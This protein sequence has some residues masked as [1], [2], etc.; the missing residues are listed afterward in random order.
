MIRGPQM[1]KKSFRKVIGTD[2]ASLADMLAKHGRGKD[3]MLAHITPGEAKLLKKLGG[4][5]TTNPKTGLPEFDDSGVADFSYQAP[6]IDTYQAPTTYSDTP[7]TDRIAAGGESFNPSS[8]TPPTQADYSQGFTTAAPAVGSDVNSWLQNDPGLAT[9]GGMTP[10]QYAQQNPGLYPKGLLP[11]VGQGTIF[12]PGSGSPQVQDP[13][14][15]QGVLATQSSAPPEKKGFLDELTSGSTLA[16]LGL[17]AGAGGLGIIQGNK[18]AK[19]SQALVNQQQALGAP[20][21][22]KGQAMIDAATSGQLSPASAQQFAAA[23]AQAQ[24][25]AQQRGG[26]G[27]QQTM[28]TLENMRQRLLA[29]DMNIGVQLAAEGDNIASGAITAQMNADAAAAQLQQNY[30]KSVFGILGQIPVGA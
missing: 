5:G 1:A 12:T 19:Q 16:K 13:N 18:A 20:Y 17:A 14:A 29:A 2:L 27:A 10:T 9:P 3:K 15:P 28:Q 22:Q 26:V 8:Y 23:S 6:P 21:Q 7:A 4:S 24:Q 30:F 25:Q 11:E